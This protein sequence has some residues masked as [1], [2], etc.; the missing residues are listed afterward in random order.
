MSGDNQKGRLVVL[1]GPS[2]VGKSTVV[3][4]MATGLAGYGVIPLVLGDLK[5][6]YVELIKALDAAMQGIVYRPGDA[7]VDEI[8]AAYKDIDR[9]MEDAED[10]VEI[11][12][13]GG[14]VGAYPPVASWS[15]WRWNSSGDSAARSTGQAA[16]I[17]SRRRSMSRPK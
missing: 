13:G 14:V 1:L 7:W 15:G 9:V 2:A 8:P 4:R 5:P 3:R 11:C 17:S 12:A 10:L 6:D 16:R